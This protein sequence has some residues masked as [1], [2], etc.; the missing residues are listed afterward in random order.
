MSI[1]AV[2]FDIDGVLLSGEW[3]SKKYSRD[4]AVDEKKF[5]AFFEGPFKKCKMGK[6][7][8]KKEI[9]KY[10]PKWNWTGGEDL[11]L[12]SWFEYENK[13]D[14]E[15]LEYIKKL[16]KK[17]FK[18]FIITGQE[19]YRL[20]YLKKR[21][22]LE[23]VF[24]EIFCSCELKAK[25]PSVKMFELIFKKLKKN[26]KLNKNEILFWDDNTKVI[27]MAEIFGFLAE[28]YINF[29]D[30]KKKIKKYNI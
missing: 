15:L 6:A 11:F 30:F 9:S 27:K 26:F 3:F 7:D 2:T 25:K 24:D 23:S 8:L 10:L 17:G 19:K 29:L 1:K 14:F 13:F 22:G 4:F 16:R 5:K 21:F 28:K 18:C 12:E 20:D